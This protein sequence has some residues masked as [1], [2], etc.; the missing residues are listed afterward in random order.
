MKYAQYTSLMS[1]NQELEVK[2]RSITEKM[3]KQKVVQ[4]I[5]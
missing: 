2:E 4:V 1:E 3:S 5:D